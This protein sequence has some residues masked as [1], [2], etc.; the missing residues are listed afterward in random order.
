MSCIYHSG[1][2]ELTAREG[3]P[4]P[5]SRWVITVR[6]SESQVEIWA[7]IR[8][9]VSLSWNIRLPCQFYFTGLQVTSVNTCMTRIYRPQCCASCFVEEI[10]V[11]SLP[12]NFTDHAFSSTMSKRGGD[13]TQL[14]ATRMKKRK[15][16]GSRTITVPDSDEEDLPPTANDY[17]QLTKTRVT[18]SGKA[19]KVTMS[20]I[21]VFEAERLSPPVPLEENVDDFVDFTGTIAPA[22]PAKRRKKVNDSVSTP[23]Y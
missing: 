7:G 22:A 21:P 23:Y 9:I 16:I 3:R 18:A 5:R 6:S 20:S 11:A 17:A 19:G 4:Q 12:I 8:Y 1:L 14:P 2:S 10:E 13:S 15:G